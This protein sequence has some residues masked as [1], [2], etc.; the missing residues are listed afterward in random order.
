[1]RLV[2]DIP[3][4][5]F[6]TALVSVS[7]VAFTIYVP[8][9]RGYFNIGEAAVYTA[10]LLGGARIGAFAGGVGSML[11]DLILGYYLFAPATLVIKGMEGGIL[12]LLSSRP[13]ALSHKAWRAISLAASLG[14]FLMVTTIGAVFYSGFSE[15]SVGL[16]WFMSLNFT[17]ELSF[18]FWVLIGGVASSF[19]A[20]TSLL[21]KPESGYLV[22]SSLLAG[23]VMVAGYFLY[24]QLLLGYVAIA[25]I[26]FNIGQVI[27]G[28]IIAVPAYASLK[29]IKRPKM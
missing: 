26:P 21:S 19:V 8:A 7:T 14:V 17:A 11:A 15:V 23:S 9:T 16:P 1:M 29:A 6:Y 18:F 28:I 12:G 13:P 4:T 20:C 2:R 24:E 5:A 3:V 27:I 25:E 22:L 10:A